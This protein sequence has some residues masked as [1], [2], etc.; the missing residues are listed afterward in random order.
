MRRTKYSIGSNNALSEIAVTM[1]STSI[2]PAREV[3]IQKIR[4]FVPCK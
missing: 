2:V 4:A 3:E 1:V